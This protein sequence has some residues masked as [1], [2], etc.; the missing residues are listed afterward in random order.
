MIKMETH[1]LKLRTIVWKEIGKVNK[2]VI[3]GIRD[4]MSN[5]SIKQ[6]IILFG[7]FL[8]EF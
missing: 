8:R 2:Q 1:P 7:H 5:M 6:S 4:I 3:D